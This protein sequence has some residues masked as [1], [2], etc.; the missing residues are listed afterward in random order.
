MTTGRSHH[1]A[2]ASRRGRRRSRL[3]RL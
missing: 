2:R 1:A 3:R